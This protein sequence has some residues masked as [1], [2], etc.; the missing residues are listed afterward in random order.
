LSK[1]NLTRQGSD[2]NFIKLAPSDLEPGRTPIYQAWWFYLLAALPLAFNAGA[3]LYQRQRSLEAG[4]VTLMRS[5]RARRLAFDRLAK[6]ERAG[7]TNAREF[8]DQ[9]AIALSGYL[10][11]RYQIPGI[12]VTADS[13]ERTLGEMDIPENAVRDAVACLQECDFGR[14]VSASPAVEK[15]RDIAKRIR[16][17]IDALERR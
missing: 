4:N 15:M 12:A 6:A 3:W 11:D 7:R 1:Q 5:R 14:F 9:A 2:I 16:N 10:S 13:L 17:T 8:Y